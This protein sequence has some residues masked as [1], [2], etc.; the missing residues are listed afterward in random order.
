M[1]SITDAV[2]NRVES[3]LFPRGCTLSVVT[4]EKGFAHVSSFERIAGTSRAAALPVSNTY[5]LAGPADAVGR[6]PID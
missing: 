1:T 4:G 3:R 2:S 6:V 5:Q